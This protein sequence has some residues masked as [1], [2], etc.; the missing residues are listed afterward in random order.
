MGSLLI[1][2]VFDLAQ[3]GSL[4]RPHHALPRRRRPGRLTK[5]SAFSYETMRLLANGSVAASF[6]NVAGQFAVGLIA[7][8]VGFVAVRGPFGA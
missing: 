3:R 8:Y 5:F 2:L 1:G 6:P 7:V 4:P